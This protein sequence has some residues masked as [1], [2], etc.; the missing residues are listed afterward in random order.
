MVL[1]VPKG[2]RMEVQSPRW[3]LL[4]DRGDGSLAA[5]RV[6]MAGRLR[7]RYGHGGDTT[8]WRLLSE[9][10]G[11]IRQNFDLSTKVRGAAT[12]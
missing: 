7:T 4:Q 9:W 1:C 5:G 10:E 6:A 8:R 11:R 2:A 3:G 12:F